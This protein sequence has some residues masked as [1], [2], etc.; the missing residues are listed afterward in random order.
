MFATAF[1]Y[2]LTNANHTTLYVGVTTDLAARV[3]EHKAKQDQRS[4]TSRYNIDKLVYYESFA[5]LLDA[6]AREKELKGRSRQY[7]ES[8]ISQ[9]NPAWVEVS[10]PMALSSLH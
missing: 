5:T 2:I 4:F 1:V 3:W 10:V 9:G 8:L 6:I 7:K